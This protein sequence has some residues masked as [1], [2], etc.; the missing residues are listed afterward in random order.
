M[1]H[2]QEERASSVFSEPLLPPRPVRL[3]RRRRRP[4]LSAPAALLVSVFLSS[5]LET[6]CTRLWAE[7]PC[8]FEIQEEISGKICYIFNLFLMVLKLAEALLES[9]YL[10]SKCC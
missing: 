2:R 7:Q 1:N 5:W 6:V 8:E 9:K 4:G 10:K 3:R